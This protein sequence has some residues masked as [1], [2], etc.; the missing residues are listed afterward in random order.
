MDGS[1]MIG[2]M[3]RAIKDKEAE[4]FK[5]LKYY[6]Q[7]LVVGGMPECVKQYVETKDFNLIRNTQAMIL[8]SYLS[9]M[10]KYN[11]NNEIKK[12]R[13]V[14]SSA[15]VQL[16]KKNTQFQYKLVKKGGRASE[17]ENAIEWLSLSGIVSK[18]Y[19]VEQITKPLENYKN[20]DAFK[21]YANDVGLLCAKKNIIPSDILFDSSDLNDFKGGMAENY[22]LSQLKCSGFTSYYWN[23]SNKAELDFIIQKDGKI[24]PIEV[25]SADNT[26]AKSLKVYMKKYEP[27]S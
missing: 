27:V 26:Q 4:A 12:T 20:I 10:S 16:S 21:I 9:D 15:T 1:A 11:T 7:Y 19:M 2:A 17:F 5:A 18:I 13:S 23:S 14:Y 25:K 6:R 22:V 3:S 8:E 24:I